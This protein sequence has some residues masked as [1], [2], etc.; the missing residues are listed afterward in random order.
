MTTIGPARSVKH[1]PLDGH[2]K[3][4]VRAEMRQTLALLVL[5]ATVAISRTAIGQTLIDAGTVNFG[6]RTML[7]YGVDVPDKGQSCDDGKWFPRAEATAALVQF[8]SDKP[9]SCFQVA[10]DYKK[11]MP[12]ALCFAE[13]RDVQ[14]FLVS[15]GWAWAMRPG[16]LKYV[17]MERLAQKSRLGLHAHQCER[18]DRWRRRNAVSN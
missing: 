1:G 15:G 11:D 9:L 12:E 13:G 18:A 4:R 3:S 7:L 2:P 16:T 14:A 17:D 10:F 5:L 8:I 6:G